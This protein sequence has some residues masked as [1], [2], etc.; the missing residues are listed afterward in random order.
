MNVG[1]KFA[2]TQHHQVLLYREQGIREYNCD[3]RCQVALLG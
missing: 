3:S 2:S 1:V